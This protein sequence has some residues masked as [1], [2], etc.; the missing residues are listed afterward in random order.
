MDGRRFEVD[1]VKAVG[2]AAVVWIHSMRHIIEARSAIEQILGDVT[3]FAVPGFLAASAYLYAGVR[4]VTAAV[5]RRRLAR[6][7][8][9]YVVA[10]LA[11]QVFW[12]GFDARPLEAKRILEELLLASSFGPFYY[13]LIAT[14]FV[15]L[16]PV[17]ARLGG[18]ALSA[19]VVAA[20]AVQWWYW[21]QAVPPL[22]WLVRN[23]LYWA[24]FFL[25]GWW[26]GAH[27][28]AVAGWLARRRPWVAVPSAVGLAA[29]LALKTRPPGLTTSNTL[30]WLSV[31]CALALLFALGVGR[32]GEHR[33]VRF[34]SDST[35]AIYLFHLFF[36]LPVQRAWPAPPGA[37]DPLPLGAAWLAGMAGPLALVLAGRA[38][39]GARSRAILG[40]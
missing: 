31:W 3:R 13:V 33:V 25:V 15:L 32:V 38:L 24:G 7:L 19:T 10:S 22:F 16:V 26:L 5:T 27:A 28:P 2:I 20:L 8:L 35:Y 21:S 4:P 9:P 14:L 40:A 29:S 12:L 18:A 39:L 17:L 23:P 37:F 11:A 34:L 30:A 1:L 6:L 36:V